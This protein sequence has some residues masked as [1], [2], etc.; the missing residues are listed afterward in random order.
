VLKPCSQVS[1]HAKLAKKQVDDVLG[2][3]EAW[4][5]VQKTDGK[6]AVLPAAAIAG[7]GAVHAAAVVAMVQQ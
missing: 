3:D 6:L 4:K 5:N 2:G 1:K 7:A